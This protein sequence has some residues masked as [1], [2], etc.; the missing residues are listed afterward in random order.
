VLPPEARHAL[1]RA[2]CQFC[3]THPCPRGYTPDEW[4][5]ECHGEAWA[6]VPDVL[7][8]YTAAKGCLETYLYE[9]VQK[10]LKSVYAKEC[11]WYQR[12]PLLLDAPLPAEGAEEGEPW[13]VVDE[14]SVGLAE[15]LCWRVAVEEALSHLSAIDRLLV[16]WAWVAGFSQQEVAQRLREQGIEM[17]QQAVSKRLKRVRAFLRDCLGGELGGK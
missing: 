13:E 17:T 5:A 3:K 16:E 4:R 6:I 2:V 8:T 11:R 9:A 12:H 15:Q 14:A 10:H 1:E 7:R